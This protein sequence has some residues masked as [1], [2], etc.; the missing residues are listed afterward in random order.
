MSTQSIATN[1]H[2][3]AET[4]TKQTSDRRSFR[5][6]SDKAA[7][8]AS[9]TERP[10]KPDTS[11]GIKVKLRGDEDS[12]GLLTRDQ[13]KQLFQELAHK[14]EADYPPDTRFKWSTFYTTPIDKDG[15]VVTAEGPR[16]Q[17]ISPYKAA[18]DQMKP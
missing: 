18:A 6:K 11:K 15:N 9:D 12:D 10:A 16:H 3:T 13:L 7:A 5:R 17:T 14:V 4:E 1:E 2:T 8:D